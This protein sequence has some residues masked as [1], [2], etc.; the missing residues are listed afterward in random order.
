MKLKFGMLGA[1]H[2][3][4]GAHVKVTSEN[5]EKFEM[6]GFYEPDQEFVERNL[7]DWPRNFAG[8]QVN[9]F[10]TAEALLSSEIEAVVVEGEVSENAAYARQA[11]EA[12]KHVLLEKPPGGR[13]DEFAAL[14]DFAREQDLVLNLAYLFRFHPDQRELVRLVRAGA[15]GDIFYFRAHMSKPW[16][17]H[18]KLDADFHMFKGGVYFEMAGHYLDLM[19]ALLGEPAAV[20]PHL[21]AQYGSRQHV[22]N[23][24]VVHEYERCLATVDTAA[25]HVIVD[26]TRRV[27]VYGS[28]G[29]AINMPYGEGKLDVFLE[30]PCEGLA[31]GWNHLELNLT[32]DAP[33]MLDEFAACIRREREPEFSLAHDLV[34]HR[35]LLEGCGAPDGNAMRA[36]H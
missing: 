7:T 26:D 33:T 8:I 10:P 36:G 12:G 31:V 3:H 16:A 4:R 28:K 34:V 6:V 13:L 23:A 25:M 14:Q 22:D 21:G 15:L 35:L 20:R 11:L 30:E 32:P 2:G 29:T 9:A 27:E 5:P 24:V 1:H 19:V 18:P 17:W